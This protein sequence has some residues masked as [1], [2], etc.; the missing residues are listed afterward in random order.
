M[1][2]LNT[3]LIIISIFVFILPSVAGDN[4]L[5]ERVVDTQNTD[6]NNLLGCLKPYTKV[7]TSQCSK[8]C[9]GSCKTLLI[10]M[11]KCD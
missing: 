1:K 3:L 7:N 10:R 2:I 5:Q 11:S 8:C 6:E 4:Y 9:S